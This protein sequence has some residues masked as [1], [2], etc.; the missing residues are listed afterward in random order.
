M[1]RLDDPDNSIRVISDIPP[2]QTWA[3]VF[4]APPN[5]EVAAR[6]RIETERYLGPTS[7][8]VCIDLFE[9]TKIILNFFR[10]RFNFKQEKVVL[11]QLLPYVVHHLVEMEF[12]YFGIHLMNQMVL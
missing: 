10:F 8:V 1:F 4:N 3:M 7:P 5:G 11:V 2:L 12:F 6:I 9:K